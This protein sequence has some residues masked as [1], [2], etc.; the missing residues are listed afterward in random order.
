MHL[1][2]FNTPL[3]IAGIFFTIILGLLFYAIIEHT[4]EAYFLSWNKSGIKNEKN[5]LI[6]FGAMFII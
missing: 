2:L 6:I 1:Q 4:L 5:L 3:L